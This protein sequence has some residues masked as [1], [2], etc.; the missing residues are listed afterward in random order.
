[1]LLLTQLRR[2][3]ANRFAERTRFVAFHFGGHILF[4]A[5][6]PPYFLCISSGVAIMS[7]TMYHLLCFRR[8]FIGLLTHI[9]K[10]SPLFPLPSLMGDL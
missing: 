5:E 9:S 3:S 8:G 2:N 6:Q 4:Q 1:M 7:R 10:Y